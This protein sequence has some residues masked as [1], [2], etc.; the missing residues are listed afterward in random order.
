[1]L[2]DFERSVYIWGTDLST[3]LIRLAVMHAKGCSNL[4]Q[5]KEGDKERQ[6][7]ILSIN[8]L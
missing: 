7:V 5:W 3:S 2:F 4:W 8:I 1:M 6:S